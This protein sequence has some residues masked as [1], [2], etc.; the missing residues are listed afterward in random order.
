MTKSR[1]KPGKQTAVS[2]DPKR[3][4]TPDEISARF[5]TVVS[6]FIGSVARPVYYHLVSRPI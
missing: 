4:F 3:T 6:L 2:P 1:T 5:K